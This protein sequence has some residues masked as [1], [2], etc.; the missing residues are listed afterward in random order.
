MAI[1]NDEGWLAGL[2]ATHY[3]AAG[4]YSDAV[5]QGS[6]LD[7]TAADDDDRNLSTTAKDWLASLEVAMPLPIGDNGSAFEPQ[8]QLIYS[9]PHVGNS[10]D[11]AGLAYSFDNN[12][13]LIG[14][15]GF[16]LKGTKDNGDGDNGR[17][18][19]TGYLKANMWATLMGGESSMM[20]G[21]T[22]VQIQG[23]S[24]WADAGLGFTVQ[25]SKNLELFVD[26]GM[27]YGLNQRYSAFVGSA[28]IRFNW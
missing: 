24:L 14:R 22:P 27:E 18:L 28:G 26:G 11:S 21:T 15:A 4:W 23:K 19:V 17:G 5:L 7:M 25:G 2:Y 20:A 10:T 1:N 16:R 9:S 3:N 12:D 6:W 13:S 8:A